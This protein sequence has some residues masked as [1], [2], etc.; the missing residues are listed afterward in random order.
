MLNKEML[1]ILAGL[2]ATIDALDAMKRAA[3][4]L[5]AACYTCDGSAESERA[6]FDAV[7]TLRSAGAACARVAENV[8]DTLRYQYPLRY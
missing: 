4:A 7:D 1:P 5:D 3:L 6:V 2:P 8:D